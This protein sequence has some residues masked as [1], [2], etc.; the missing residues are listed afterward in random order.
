MLDRP[1]RLVRV[2]REGGGRGREAR[3]KKMLSRESFVRGII[4]LAARG[5]KNQFPSMKGH[6]C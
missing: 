5:F 4:D 2:P 6:A 3:M 1:P